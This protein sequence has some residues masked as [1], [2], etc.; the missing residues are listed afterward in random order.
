MENSAIRKFNY[1]SYNYTPDFIEQVWFDSPLLAGHLRT[2]FKSYYTQVGSNA[3]ML[4]FYVNL[5]TDHQR[6]L[7]DWIIEN[8]NC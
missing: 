7:E 3:V 8:Y 5:S 1:F 2:K 6:K 4:L